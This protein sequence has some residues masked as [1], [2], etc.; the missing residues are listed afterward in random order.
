MKNFTSDIIIVGS[1]MAGLTAAIYAMRAGKSVSVFCGSNPGGKITSSFNVENYP[2]ILSISGQDLGDTM[3]KQAKSFGVNI[4]YKTVK[5]LNAS[6]KS[7]TDSEQNVYNAK[8]II[9]ATGM[10][11]RKSSAVDARKFEGNGISYCAVCDGPLYRGKTAAVIG[12]GNSSLSEALYLSDICEKV[13][14][15]HRRQDF[16][17]EKYLIKKTELVKNIICIMNTTVLS[18][19]GNDTLKSID[20]LCKG[21]RETIS[22]DAVFPAIGYVPQSSLYKDIVTTDTTGFAITD[23]NCTTNVEGIYVAGDCRQK[24]VRQLTTA[25]A[26]GTAAAFN[27]CNYIDSL[28]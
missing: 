21:N 16:R 1:G 20:V 24:P 7:V 4:L 11:N 12:G 5:E 28:A 15:I 19:N 14:I 23:E 3:L 26:D 2:G 8:G 6:V 25:A 18:F 10:Q 22:V 17:A 27:C 13:Y 9:I